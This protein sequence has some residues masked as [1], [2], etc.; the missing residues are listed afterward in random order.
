MVKLKLLFKKALLPIVLSALGFGAITIAGVASYVVYSTHSTSVN[1]QEY[2]PKALPSGITST[3][4]SLDV[5]SDKTSFLTHT[6]QLTFD[7]NAPHSFISET[8]NKPFVYQCDNGAANATCATAET[9]NHQQYRLT[10]VYDQTL[11]GKP[12]E[13][14]VAWLKGNTYIW[15]TLQGNPVHTYSQGEWGRVIDS[16]VPVHY[17][18]ITIKQYSPGP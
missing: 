16:F 6:K 5:W 15:I 8:R 18:R 11:A 10:T 2:E 13:Q 9:P 17:S 3:G 7:L 12:F 14:T 4:R 1:F